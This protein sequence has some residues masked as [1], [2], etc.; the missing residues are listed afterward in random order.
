MNEHFTKS[1]CDHLMFTFFFMFLSPP[2][3]CSLKNFSGS[4][5]VTVVNF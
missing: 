2:K 3:P 5:H 1:K 4:Q